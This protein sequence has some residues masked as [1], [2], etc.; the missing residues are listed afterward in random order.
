MDSMFSLELADPEL[1]TWLDRA[2][3]DLT[4]GPNAPG[5]GDIVQWYVTVCQI[6]VMHL[7]GLSDERLAEK[8]NE[9]PSDW[10]PIRG[11]LPAALRLT[12]EKIFSIC[13]T[14]PSPAQIASINFELDLIEA[15]TCRQWGGRTVRVPKRRKNGDYRQAVRDEIAKG[16]A[17]KDIASIVG[18]DR[19]TVYRILKEKN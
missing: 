10:T 15:E 18:I 8:R 17:I 4:I 16:V 14:Q 3:S 19:A 1:R 2:N 5:D 9:F 12:G 7:K 13:F 11:G 6:G